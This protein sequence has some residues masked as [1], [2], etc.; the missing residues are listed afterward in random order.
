MNFVQESSR[1]QL[2]YVGAFIPRRTANLGCLDA[3]LSLRSGGVT[4]RELQQHENN[5]H[6]T[7][8]PHTHYS[9]VLRQ[10]GTCGIESRNSRRACGRRRP[11]DWPSAPIPTR[12]GWRGNTAWSG[13]R[14]C[15]TF[16]SK[17]ERESG[18]TVINGRRTCSFLWM[19]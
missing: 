10:S 16:S 4:D 5:C 14:G 15:K 9:S 1:N 17:R 12:D 6:K 19:P 7:G 11:S 8:T 2:P 18:A 3:V 13:H